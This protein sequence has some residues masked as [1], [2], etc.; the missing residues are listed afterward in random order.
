[1]VIWSFALSFV[2]V[3]GLFLAGKRMKIGWLVALSNEVLWLAYTIATAQWGFLIA[4]SIYSF[5]Y[6]QNYVRWRDEDVL[7]AGCG[8]HCN[9][10]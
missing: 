4:I 8:P 7:S 9:Q 5:V 6:V 10:G 1:M 2:G 3:L